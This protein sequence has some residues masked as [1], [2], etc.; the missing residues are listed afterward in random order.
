MMIALGLV[1]MWLTIELARAEQTT[2][3]AMQR[4]LGYA[5]GVLEGLTLGKFD[6]VLTNSMQLRDFS[7]TNAFSATRNV[8]YLESATNFLRRVDALS[9]AANAQNL[10]RATQAYE[11]VTRSCIECHAVFRREK[12]LKARPTVPQK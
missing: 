8:T 12:S 2:R 9:Q 11:D 3:V 1:L 10:E 7:Q 5:Q 4:K 6:L